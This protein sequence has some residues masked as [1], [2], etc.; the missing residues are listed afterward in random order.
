MHFDLSMFA[1][2]FFFVI[3]YNWVQGTLTFVPMISLDFVLDNVVILLY[4]EIPSYL[5]VFF[6]FAHSLAICNEGGCLKNTV[7]EQLDEVIHFCQ[8]KLY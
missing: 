5:F 1:S 2:I 3:D 4:S 7:D 8:M 6:L